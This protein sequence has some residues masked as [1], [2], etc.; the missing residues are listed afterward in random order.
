MKNSKFC[1]LLSLIAIGLMTISFFIDDN[2]MNQELSEKSKV[3]YGFAAKTGE[4]LGKKY[5]MSP[6]GIGGGGGP[7]EEGIWLISLVFDRY[8]EPLTENM[9]RQLI[10][11]CVDDFLEAV[12][13]DKQLKPF[14]KEYPFTA[15]N[16]EVSIHNYDHNGYQIAEPFIVTV[17]MSRGKVGYY[18]VEK[19]DSLPFKTKK[20]ESF[21]EAVAILK[22]EDKTN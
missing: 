18:T 21:D 3:M 15:K 12:N 22:E 6:A 19:Q 7:K 20:Y 2:K 10:V 5:K 9:A 11:N 17:N 4:K 1:L 14:L 16:L 13:N 8:G